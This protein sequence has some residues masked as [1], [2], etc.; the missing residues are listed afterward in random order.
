MT[1]NRRNTQRH[2]ITVAPSNSKS[3][4]GN[5]LVTQYS[6]PQPAHL[7]EGHWPSSHLSFDAHMQ[8]PNMRSRH[9]RCARRSHP[10]QGRAQRCRKCCGAGPGGA[11]SMTL[12]T[13]HRANL[14][15]PCGCVRTRQ[16][17]CHVVGGGSGGGGA[18]AGFS[19]NNITRM[20]GKNQNKWSN[21]E[22]APQK[23]TAKGHGRGQASSI[24]ERI[25]WTSVLCVAPCSEPQRNTKYP[26][27]METRS[28]LS[29]MQ[30]LV[31][32]NSATSAGSRHAH[33]RCISPLVMSPGRPSGVAK[34]AVVEH[35]AVAA[36]PSASTEP[37]PAIEA[38][39]AIP[40]ALL[41]LPLP[42]LQLGLA[43]K[44]L[45]TSPS[46]RSLDAGEVSGNASARISGIAGAA[47]VG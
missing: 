15:A 29:A 41:S 17:I 46:L 7:K 11:T 13:K 39:L 24:H 18:R 3:D 20:K 40:A 35:D 19:M 43:G 27:H 28:R 12:Q 6:C 47:C 8:L 37:L 4:S 45:A 31:H 1:N 38:A 34:Y 44:P 2:S 30:A 5:R 14:A 21:D 23:P 22:R 26:R 25:T 33:T 9:D 16:T 36:T 32:N 42:A 10:E